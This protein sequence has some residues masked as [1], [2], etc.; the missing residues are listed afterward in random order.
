[1]RKVLPMQKSY[2]SNEMAVES[3]LKTSKNKQLTKTA[4]FTDIHW[5]CKSNSEEHNQD[6][7]RYID[8]FCEQVRSDP[9]IDSIVFIGDWFET[10]SAVNVMTLQYSYEGAKKL[11][12]LGL[13]VY[14]VIGNHDLYHRHTR[15]VYSTSHFEE[16]ANFHIINEPT[17]VPELGV[18]G[19]LISPFLFPEEYNTLSQYKNLRVWWGHFEFKGFVVTGYNITMPTGP[20]PAEFDGPA[21]IFCGH[22]HKRQ[23]SRNITYI[24]NT[25]PTNFADSGDTNRGMMVYDHIADKIVFHNWTDCPSYIKVRLTDL[26]DGSVTLTQGA[27]VK[28][29]VDVPIS[30]QESNMLRQSMIEEYNLREFSMEESHEKN[31]SIEDTETELDLSEENVEDG[32][33]RTIDELVIQM[34]SEIK[35]EVI[36]NQILIEQ[37]KRLTV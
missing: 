19:N 16:F 24:G 28:C 9:S 10:R 33:I 18:G 34:L 29:I 23:T 5:G 26:I 7:A 30:F 14:F 27:R 4:A 31:E 15:K 13:P 8:W 25:F 3:K 37:Y 1:M 21:H 2:P 12:Q 6:C 17:V 36:D 20:D 22:F 35:N 11:N 32:D